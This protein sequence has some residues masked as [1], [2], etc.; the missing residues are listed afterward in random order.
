MPDFE[1][2]NPGQMAE[3]DRLQTEQQ[4]EWKAIP[5]SGQLVD[6]DGTE[7]LVMPGV[8]PP[9]PDTRLLIDILEIDVGC[10]VL[11]LGTGTGALAIWAAR[12]GAD[13]VLATDVAGA[14]AYNARQ[15]VQRLGLERCIEVRSGNMFACVS[16][17]ETFDMIL[18]NLPGR[19][20]A[21]TDDMAAAQWDTGFKAH[22]ALFESAA[23]HLTAVGAI[24]MAQANYPELSTTVKLA[25]S[26]GFQA[27]I[28]ARADA[29]GDDPRIYYALKFEIN[30]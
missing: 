17:F 18:A 16:R 29:Q 7:L 23:R 9:R 6:L 25:E 24:Y 4:Q 13:R 30:T 28:V 11:D 14:A 8:F 1:I 27:R 19:N 2:L 10:A 26:N 12:Q 20:K 15:N 21:A 5:A 3:I 22:R